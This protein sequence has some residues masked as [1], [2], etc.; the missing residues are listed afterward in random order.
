MQY[1]FKVFGL[2]SRD[3]GPPVCKSGTLISRWVRAKAAVVTYAMGVVGE[4]ERPFPGALGSSGW[5]WGM[6]GPPVPM[7]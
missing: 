1:T 6:D 4:V 3:W 2:W 7:I 5:R